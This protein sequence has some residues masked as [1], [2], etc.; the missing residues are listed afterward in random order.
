MNF[1]SFLVFYYIA[2]L[3][4]GRYASH[5]CDFYL[6]DEAKGQFYFVYLY[7]RVNNFCMFIYLIYALLSL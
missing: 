5:A 1:H 4:V 6:S 3:F 2:S 7:V